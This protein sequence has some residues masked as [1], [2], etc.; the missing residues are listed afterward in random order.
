MKWI[1]LLPMLLLAACAA[2]AGAPTNAELAQGVVLDEAMSSALVQARKACPGLDAYF[3]DL[4]VLAVDAPE[5]NVTSTVE[6]DIPEKSSKVPDGFKAWGNR[7]ELRIEA[8]RAST[9]KRACA[10]ACLLRQHSGSG[11]PYILN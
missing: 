5:S 1:T 11:P 9:T 6:F 2:P 3:P 10:S 4:R 7:C 8:G